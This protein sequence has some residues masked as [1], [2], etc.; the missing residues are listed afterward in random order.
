MA[1]RMILPELR[2]GY[3]ASEPPGSP[4]PGTQAFFGYLGREG[5]TPHVATLDE[6]NTANGDGELRSMGIWVPDFSSTP[7]TEAKAAA[8]AAYRLG[9]DRER[10]RFIAVDGET[11]KKGAWIR[12][13]GHRLFEE[14]FD[15]LDY[16][17]LLV[18]L[19]DPSGLPE[20]TA[21]YAPPPS[22]FTPNQI[23]VQYAAN[24]PFGDTA[25]DLSVFGER[26]WSGLGRNKRHIR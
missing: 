12:E 26:L 17:S 18:Q 22:S 1:I 2:H 14:G 16:R 6:W 7:A 10:G 3:D 13:F 4:Y 24:L 11:L 5:F 23:A 15:A 8:D 25:V 21:H 9:W 19:Q 20:W